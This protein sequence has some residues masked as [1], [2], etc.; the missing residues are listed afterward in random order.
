MHSHSPNE[1][2]GPI[3]GT[4]GWWQETG[5]ND[6]HGDG[7][8]SSQATAPARKKRGK[9]TSHRNYAR[10]PGAPAAGASIRADLVERVRKEIEDGTYETTEKW[11]AALDRLL[12]NL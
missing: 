4:P 11:E 5:K 8:E 9:K 6:K 1:L 3:R 12:E 2:Q 7:G 10:A